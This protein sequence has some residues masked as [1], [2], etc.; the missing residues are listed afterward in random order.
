[1]NGSKPASRVLAYAMFGSIRQLL[2]HAKPEEKE[3]FAQLTLVDP[4]PP[5][6]ITS[7]RPFRAT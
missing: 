3:M 5:F 4:T 6:T 1:M 7:F 2:P